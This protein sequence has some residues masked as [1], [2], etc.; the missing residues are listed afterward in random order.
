VDGERPELFHRLDEESSARVRR[1]TIDHGLTERVR[2]RNVIYPEASAAFRA[3]GGTS[4]P[5]LWTGGQL[6]VGAELIIARLEALLDL[7]RSD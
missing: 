6:F 5:A 2:F 4:T 7:G 1:W 3:H